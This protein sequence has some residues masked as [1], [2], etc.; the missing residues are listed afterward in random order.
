VTS[1]K[2]RCPAC[3]SNC[4]GTYTGSCVQPMIPTF[5]PLPVLKALPRCLPGERLLTTT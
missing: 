5:K 3:E 2:N 1:N 4:L